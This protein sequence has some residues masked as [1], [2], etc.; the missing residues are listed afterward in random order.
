MCSRGQVL[1]GSQLAT[2]PQLFPTGHQIPTLKWAS[3]VP[4]VLVREVGTFPTA[5]S[6]TAR[7]TYTGQVE[8]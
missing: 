2:S 7:A 5:K 4:G 1:E 3:W 6:Q 8:V